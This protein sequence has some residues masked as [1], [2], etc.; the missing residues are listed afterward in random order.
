MTYRVTNI[1]F[2]AFDLED[3]FDGSVAREYVEKAKSMLFD[4]NSREELES[5]IHHKVAAI[6]IYK[7][8]YEEV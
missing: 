3:D 2:D 4:A 7:L 1:E 8:E 5:Q 6:N